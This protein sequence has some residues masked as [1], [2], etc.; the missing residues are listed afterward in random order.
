M[1]KDLWKLAGPMILCHIL[2]TMFNIVDMIW[3]GRLGAQET[4]AV[5]W[6]GNILIV[7][8]TLIIGISTGTTAI[9]TRNIGAKENDEAARTAFHS[10]ILGLVSAGVLA[11]LGFHYIEKLMIIFGAEGEIARMSAG[12]LKIIFVFSVVLF[13]MYLMSAILQGSGDVKTP[14]KAVIYATILNFILD[15]ILIFGLG[16]FPALGVNGAAIST[17]IARTLGTAVCVYAL[18][19][20]EHKIRII[21]RYMKINFN[22]FFRILKIGIPGSLQ[23]M[24][25]S[26]V[27]F[28]ILILV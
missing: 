20:K 21:P 5:S 26:V 18:F 17:V 28:V 14:L 6:A 9:I 12:Y 19:F 3:I 1:L 24:L 15:P 11:F 22:I 7:L 23:M 2:Q 16:F 4:A 25:R 13:A 10:L 27:G 8:L